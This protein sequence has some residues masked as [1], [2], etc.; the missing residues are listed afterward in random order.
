[1]NTLRKFIKDLLTENDGQSYCPV[2]V[3]A[4][5]LSLPAVTLF[6]VGY[7]LQILHGHFDGQGFSTSFATMTAGFMAFGISVAA[8]AFTDKP[9]Q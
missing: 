8:K 7:T 1:M 4:F 9:I 6:T 5:F 3:F 2:R